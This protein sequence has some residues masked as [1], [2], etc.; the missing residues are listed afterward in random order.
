M[1]PRIPRPTQLSNEK[2][3]PGCL[4]YSIVVELQVEV[5]VEV[6][7]VVM[8]LVVLM[9]LV[10]GLSGFMKQMR[11]EPHAVGDIVRAYDFLATNQR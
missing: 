9:V 8:V 2:R 5:Q 7:V 11:V 6:Q 1:H 3:A 4:G 10:R